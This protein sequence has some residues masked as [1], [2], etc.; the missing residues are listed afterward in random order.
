MAPITAPFPSDEWFAEL[1][2]RGSADT[3]TID[4]L[5]IAEL[6]LGVEVVGRDGRPDLFGIVL[7]GYELRSAGRVTED[8]FGAEVVLTG[9][10]AA[11]QEMVAAIEAN[12]GADGA[13]TLNTLSLA[14]V[15]L[16]VRADDAV[17]QDKLFRYMGT[18]QA[19]FDAAG[20]PAA[21]VV[22]QAS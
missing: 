2:Q 7:D 6:R 8:G 5:G 21:T 14:G 4:R 3:A 9:A 17:G 18:V 13:H 19:V 1:V 20:A 11:W 15:P 12:G 10:L 22:H 16:A